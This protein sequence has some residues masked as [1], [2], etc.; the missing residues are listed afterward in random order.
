MNKHRALQSL[1]RVV[2]DPLWQHPPQ[3]EHARRRLG[4]F[5]VLLDGLCDQHEVRIRL[6]HYSNLRSAHVVVVFLFVALAR[7]PQLAR[8]PD[9][10]TLAYLIAFLR[11][12]V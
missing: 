8:Q 12:G 6:A 11:Q 1:G 2:P 3:V 4:H 5:G 10:H 9:S 7:Q